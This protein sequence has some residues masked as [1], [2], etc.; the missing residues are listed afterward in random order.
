MRTKLGSKEVWLRTRL[1]RRALVADQ[2]R[3][4]E[5]G[6]RTKLDRRLGCGPSS[7]ASTQVLVAMPASGEWS[8]PGGSFSRGLTS[9][10]APCRHALLLWRVAPTG[11]DVGPMGHKVPRSLSPCP[12]LEG[13]ADCGWT[14]SRELAFKEYDRGHC[15]QEV[16]PASRPCR[17]TLRWRAVQTGRDRSLWLSSCTSCCES[18]APTWC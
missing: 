9:H 13:G 2:D 7:T 5:V 12:Q 8:R 18:F 3:Q 4:K 11:R 17:R 14:L 16:I 10:T 1:D 15:D 6:L